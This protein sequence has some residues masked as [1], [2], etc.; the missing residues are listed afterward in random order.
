MIMD[1]KKKAGLI[2]LI[3]AGVIF[4]IVLASGIKDK[5]KGNPEEAQENVYTEVPDGNVDKVTDSKTDAY[6]S[7]RAAS[8][9]INDY[10]DNCE[11]ELIIEEELE[12]KNS[13]GG[14][15][16]ATSADLFG[17][18][19]P[20]PSRSQSSGGS[21]NTYR[22]TPEQREARHQK[23]REEAIELADRMQ[24]G[25]DAEKP[26]E[27][28]DPVPQTINIPSETVHRSEVISS[29]GDWS[30]GSVSSLDETH[31]D[32][33]TDEMHPFK[34]M[35][36]REEKIKHGQRVSVR[37]LEDIVVGGQLVPKNTH[38]MAS[39]SIGSRL[40]LEITNIEMQGRILSLGYEAYD[41]DG[42]KG[43][44][45]PDVGSAGKTVKSHGTSL[46]GTA[47]SS[48]V[49]RLA[50]DIVSTGVSLA[51]SASG[52]RTVTVPAGYTFYIVK[53]RQP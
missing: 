50:S 4:A 35:F 6:M 32:I 49:G 14:T 34:C 47:L 13:G 44:Y 40:D 33:S 48:R 23:R 39:C 11:E 31:T 20:A 46:A 30:D 17:S 1:Q 16:Q 51:Q 19:S 12:Q 42:V 53:K 41:T 29:L 52:E 22:E 25:P 5:K 15:S 27:A 43:I 8:S 28:E 3:F 36:V 18:D 21:R 38:I 45:C 10:W 26:E 7:Y 2:L 9:D 24:R 37:L